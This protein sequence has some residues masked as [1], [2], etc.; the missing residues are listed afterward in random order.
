MEGQTLNPPG[1]ESQCIIAARQIEGSSDLSSSS[2]N[3]ETQPKVDSIESGIQEREFEKNA[4][5]LTNV[6]VS[7]WTMAQ[8]NK[9]VTFFEFQQGT[10][11]VEFDIDKVISTY[12]GCHYNASDVFSSDAYMSIIKDA[13]SVSTLDKN[14]VICSQVL[15]KFRKEVAQ[16]FRVIRDGE[17]CFSDFI[18]KSSWLNLNEQLDDIDKEQGFPFHLRFGKGILLEE[19]EYKELKKTK[20]CKLPEASNEQEK[21]LPMPTIL[22]E[23]EQPTLSEECASGDDPLSSIQIT[24]LT[25]EEAKRYFSGE[26]SICETAEHLHSEVPEPNGEENENQI[27]LGLPEQPLIEKEKSHMEVYCCLKRWMAVM[28]GCEKK[29][30]CSCQSESAQERGQKSVNTADAEKANE[31]GVTA[32]SSFQETSDL[33]MSDKATETEHGSL[34]KCKV[35]NEVH[36]RKCKNMRTP[37]AQN[38][39]ICVKGLSELSTTENKADIVDAPTSVSSGSNVVGVEIQ[40]ICSSSGEVHKIACTVPKPLTSKCISKDESKNQQWANVDENSPSLGTTG[41][42]NASLGSVTLAKCGMFSQQEVK[43]T[44]RH[45]F[46]KYSASE[47]PSNRKRKRKQRVEIANSTST[48]PIHDDLHHNQRKRRKEKSCSVAVGK[49]KAALLDYDDRT[50]LQTKRKSNNA[51][52]IKSKVPKL[53]EGEHPRNVHIDNGENGTMPRE[54]KLF[55]VVPTHGK[56]NSVSLALYGSSPQRRHGTLRSSRPSDGKLCKSQVPVGRPSLPPA[57]I[58]LTIASEKT[59]SLEICSPVKSHAKQ[60][61]FAKWKSSF[62]STKKCTSKGKATKLKNATG[63]RKCNG[64]GPKMPCTPPATHPKQPERSTGQPNVRSSPRKVTPIRLRAVTK[65]QEKVNG[66]KR[67]LE[68]VENEPFAILDD[69]KN[70]KSTSALRPCVGGRPR[71]LTTRSLPLCDTKIMN[72]LKLG[73]VRKGEPVRQRRHSLPVT[74]LSDAET[75]RKHEI[76]NP[77]LTPVQ[78]E[79]ILEFKLLPKSFSF[80]DVQ[81]CTESVKQR[82]AKKTETDKVS[83]KQPESLKKTTWRLQGSFSSSEGKGLREVRSPSASMQSGTIF[84]EFKKRY[85]EKARK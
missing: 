29:C 57:T 17:V 55:E 44:D 30:T 7:K 67:M 19:N 81:G 80:E 77:A 71:D 79:N 61:V 8:L 46:Q 22:S 65:Q 39:E 3:S 54:E 49:I 82:Q 26:Q 31:E 36:R 63:A 4:L 56:T 35:E 38:S 23:A 76:G 41:T 27:E 16:N 85:M 70:H 1:L 5:D 20:S 21:N 62:V 48:S 74:S 43:D 40:D 13:S 52:S 28:T 18:F 14:S 34:A 11:E 84:Q 33:N 2:C 64:V 68:T 42:N 9:L 59:H 24:L 69:Q 10:C 73:R 75:K 78:G 83:S 72:K 37:V 6:P 15:H 50:C 25:H 66:E 32:K 51:E 12:G 53:V 60:Q 47:K 58:S 45:F